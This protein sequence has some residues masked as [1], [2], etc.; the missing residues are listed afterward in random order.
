MESREK[1]GA[2]EDGAV[3]GRWGRRRGSVVWYD[4]GGE[5]AGWWRRGQPKEDGAAE[6]WARATKEEDGEGERCGG[7]GRWLKQHGVAVEDGAKEQ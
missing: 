6:D 4:G 2:A 5:A 7:R 1:G 3:E